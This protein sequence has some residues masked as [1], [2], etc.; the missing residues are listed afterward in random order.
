VAGDRLIAA[1]AERLRGVVAERGRLARIAGDEFALL[2]DG[3]SDAEVAERE[4]RPRSSAK[5]SAERSSTSPRSSCAPSGSSSRSTTSARAGPRSPPSPRCRSTSSS[6]TAR[7]SPRW[8][9]HPRTPRCWTGCWRWP[10]LELPTVVEGIETQAQLD[11]VRAFGC[12]FVQGYFL[13]R[14]GP[15][16]ARRAARVA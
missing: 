13:G 12:T 4:A 2:L 3:A 14:P 10:R 8:T 16:P 7:S 6:S 11:R 5:A 15:L 9:T 1:V